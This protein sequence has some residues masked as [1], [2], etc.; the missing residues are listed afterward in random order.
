MTPSAGFPQSP[1]S[2]DSQAPTIDPKQAEIQQFGPT[3]KD[4]LANSI[5]PEI[6]AEKILQYLR[7]KRADM[8]YRGLH[9][10]YP[11]VSDSGQIN[12]AG[13]GTPK[14]Q[15]VD[16][17][18]AVYDYAFQVVKKYGEKF[19][20][21]VGARPFDNC[22]AVADNPKDEADKQA[23]REANTAIS[24]LRAWWDC[25]AKNYKLA[26]SFF[27]SGT[28]FPYVRW[29]VDGRRF[30]Y[31]YITKMDTKQ[32]QL[33]PSYYRCPQCNSETDEGGAA[34]N[35]FTCMECGGVLGGESFYQAELA[36][37]P[38][39]GQPIKY[40]NGR[41][42]LA[43]LNTT[44]ITMAFYSEGKEDT[45]FAI[46]DSD[47]PR[48]RIMGQ[49]PA[50]R[51]KLDST[52]FNSST[53]AAQGSLTRA[54]AQS[55]TGAPKSQSNQGLVSVRRIWVTP[56]KLQEIKDKAIR[57]ALLEKYP[58]GLKFVIVADTVAEITDED[59][60]NHIGVAQPIVGDY[61]MV[62]GI[63]WAI[64][65]HQDI[66][67]DM[68]EL[69]IQHLERGL[70]THIAMAGMLDIDAISK[71]RHRP[72]EIIETMPDSASTLDSAI[73]TLSTARFPDQ[74]PNLM[75]SV[76]AD[77]QSSTGMLP[78]VWG[79]T[80]S[81]RKTADQARSELNQALAQLGT[82][83]EIGM[84]SCWR[85]CFDMGIK[86]LLKFGPDN[87]SHGGQAIDKKALAAGKYHLESG[88]GIPKTEQE[89]KDSIKDL[90]MNANTPAS[91]SIVASFK[92]DSPDAAGVIR[93]MFDAPEMPDPTDDHR[94]VVQEII[95]QLVQ[96]QPMQNPD[97]S[98]SPSVPFEDFV[99]DPQ[100]TLI[101][102]HDWLLEPSSRA[103]YK[104]NPFGYQNVMAFGM[105]AEKRL[106]PP[107]PPPPGQDGGPQGPGSGGPPSKV[108]GPGDQGAMAGGI[109]PAPSQPPQE[110]Q[111]GPMS[112]PQGAQ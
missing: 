81:T 31:T 35:G 101:Q 12:L 68:G 94:V 30:G 111:A 82:T 85:Q 37:V 46:L 41:V 87:L 110:T 15:Q 23:A 104:Q 21:V 72:Q 109:P 4:L 6:S 36:N 63:C 112:P 70:P 91:Q 9:H 52:S 57:E 22:E 47:E 76:D 83:G 59:F 3:L 77:I 67:N 53:I 86:L 45:P 38:V 96:G 7:W 75:E 106:Q 33:A 64:L 2:P 97:G 48:G 26:H 39:E 55:Q 24:M 99:L 27:K 14:F 105:D 5:E 40:P 79:M 54:G 16:T 13:S 43:F 20:A 1:I 90:V 34:N 56:D 62:D 44:K 66:M 92:L 8:Y 95:E 84:S 100:S 11:E 93:D 61:L 49:Y 50:L 19:T 65:G 78:Q 25:R 32:V 69:A 73:K 102:V 88:T 10:V 17:E 29:V 89:R 108:Q 98:M 42:D 80:D 74:L 103:L 28:T 107:M 51:D 58:T 60:L 18:S 71:R